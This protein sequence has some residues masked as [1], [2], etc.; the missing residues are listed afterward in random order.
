MKLSILKSVKYRKLGAA[1][2]ETDCSP[3]INI[4]AEV[5]FSGLPVTSKIMDL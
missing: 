2:Q 1:F 4:C 3:K 5:H